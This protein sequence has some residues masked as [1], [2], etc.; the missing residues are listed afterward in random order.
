MNRYAYRT[1]GLAIKTLS[2]LS[3]ASVSIYGQTHIPDGAKIF[4][5]NHFTRIETLLLP[6]HIYELTKQPVWSLASHEF[7][8]GSLGTFWRRL[9]QSPQ[10]TPTGTA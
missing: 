5:I 4:V 8:G 9:A 1:T 2:A 6:Y 7:F 3:R 10:K